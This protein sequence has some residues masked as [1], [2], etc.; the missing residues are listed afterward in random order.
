M[1]LKVLQIARNPDYKDL[2]LDF[3]KNPVTGD[4]VKK[5]G[6][7]AVKRAVRNLVMSNFFERPFRSHIGSGARQML[8]D[9]INPMTATALREAIIQVITNFEPRARLIDVEVIAAGPE[10]GYHCNIYFRIVNVQQPIVV[11]L[12]LERIR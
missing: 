4:L 5:T 11:S 10:N 3:F 9:M 1:V 8:F 6:A 12:F 7:E 2:D